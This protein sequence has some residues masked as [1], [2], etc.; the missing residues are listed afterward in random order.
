ML[1]SRN[2]CAPLRA[3]VRIAGRAHIV[4]QLGVCAGCEEHAHG[5]HL[6]SPRSV[7]ERRVPVLCG[8]GGA[9]AQ[10]QRHHE[11][12]L[13]ESTLRAR[14]QRPP[15]SRGA[16]RAQCPGRPSARPTPA[17]AAGTLRSRPAQRSA[18]ECSASGSAR[19]AAAPSAAGTRGRARRG[20]WRR[21]RAGPCSRSAGPAGGR[22]RLA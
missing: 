21:R 13:R 17:G 1:D 10:K 7:H 12:E 6:A 3:Q 16:A 18:G 8:G 20:P 19:R 22:I 2:N 9:Q 15:R 11:R 5:I 4:L 14:A